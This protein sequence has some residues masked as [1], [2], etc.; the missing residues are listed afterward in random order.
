LAKRKVKK[1]RRDPWN[2]GVTVGQRDP[3]S[4]AEVNQ[5]KKQLRRRGEAGRR[6][7]ALFSTAIDTMLRTPDLLGLLVK[8]VRKRDGAMRDTFKLAASDVG[9]RSIGI[10]CTLSKTTMKVLDQWISQA[11][12]KQG[13]YLFTGRIGGGQ[14]ALSSR[15]L[16]RLVKSWAVGIGLDEH[17]YGIES[18][19]RTRAI[20]I[21]NRTGNLEVLRELLGHTTVTKTALYLRDASS[22]DE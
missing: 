9:Q 1:T 14:I 12:K 11:G 16:S 3:F 13:D 20:Q 17:L 19:R 10:Q 5:I 6:D 21:L 8:D 15:Q 18:L 22:V 2:K 7:L 4:T